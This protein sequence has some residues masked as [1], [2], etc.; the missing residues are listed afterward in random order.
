M[1]FVFALQAGVLAFLLMRARQHI[2]WTATCAHVDLRLLR[3]L[4]DLVAHGDRDGIE[5]WIASTRGSWVGDVGVAAL[6]VA[7]GEMAGGE[8]IRDLQRQFHARL[9]VLHGVA[10]ITSVCTL[11]AVVVELSWGLTGGSG[12]EALQAG[13]PQQIAF[14]NVLASLA[15]GLVTLAVYM[16]VS[17]LLRARMVQATKRLRG[18]LS[19]VQSCVAPSRGVDPA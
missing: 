5:R 2:E 19:E 12:L 8:T 16:W 11:L 6:D 7:K 9:Y 1:P 17:R 15:L 3:R 4:T 13:L 18:L 14:R 10:R